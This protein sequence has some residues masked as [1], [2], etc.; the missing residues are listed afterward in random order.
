[1]DVIL[2]EKVENLGNLG[3]KV[4]VKPGYGRNYLIPSGKATPA[5]AENLEA[6]EKKRAELE[7]QAGDALAY[8]ESRKQQLEGKEVQI[9]ANAGEEGKLF[10][11]VSTADIADA[12]TAT[13]VEVSK[14]EVRLPEGPLRHTG[15][16]DIQIHLHT[17]VNTSIKLVI[18]AE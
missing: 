14:K 2:L 4:H 10:G 1:M 16:F 11:S 9:T 17:D 5:T 3:D 8:A 6:F 12:I 18:V 15:E 13:G 7:K